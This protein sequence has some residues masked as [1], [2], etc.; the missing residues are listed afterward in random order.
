M[1]P[2][3]GWPAGFYQ[4]APGFRVGVVVLTELPGTRETIPLRLFGPAEVRDGLLAEYEALADDD[5]M[6]Q[7]VGSRLVCWTMWLRGQPGDQDLQRWLMTFQQVVQSELNKLMAEA[8]AD[9]R[10]A[11]LAAG[12]AMGKAEGLAAGKAEGH[13]EG[14]I[15][16]LRVAITDLCEVLGVALTPGQRQHLAGLDLDGLEA[17]R[18]HLKQHRAWPG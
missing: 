7:T 6:R 1:A 17:L 4:T 14:Q 11:G 15:V 2:A 16:G 3:A 13:M 5:P 12:L 10:A 9:S 8:T 18:L